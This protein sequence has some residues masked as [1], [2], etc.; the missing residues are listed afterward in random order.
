MPW[1]G[2]HLP[3][4][5]ARYWLAMLF[6][7][8]IGTKLGDYVYSYPW[9]YDQELPAI[10]AVFVVVLLAENF[11]KRATQFYYWAVIVMA[12]A[13]ATNLAD[14][15]PNA[16]GFGVY[17][18]DHVLGALLAVTLLFGGFLSRGVALREGLPPVDLR[19][20][21]AMTT[22]SMLACAA[23]D[24]V[25]GQM[26]V[27]LALPSVL[28]G[29]AF[30]LVVCRWLRKTEAHYWLLIA[31]ALAAGAVGADY[32]TNAWSLSSGY[33]MAGLIIALGVLVRF[34][35]RDTS[36]GGVVRGL[37]WSACTIWAFSVKYRRPLSGLAIVAFGAW[38]GY[39]GYTTVLPLQSA[40]H[41][42]Y[43]TGVGQIRTDFHNK[44]QN[45]SQYVNPEVPSLQKSLLYYKAQAKA[46]LLDRLLY[47]RPDPALAAQAYLK[48]G[49]ILLYNA[50]HDDKLLN[51][52]KGY[53]ETAV[54]LN[55]GIPYARTLLE[56]TGSLASVNDL[57]IMA[58]APERDLEMLY[59][60]NPQQR[61]PKPQKGDG[62]SK[63][64][65]DKKGDQQG[66]PDQPNDQPGDQSDQKND[67]QA[68]ASMNKSLQ[69]NPNDVKN[70]VGNDGI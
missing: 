19:Y 17:N 48:I 4:V 13:T 51:E 61:T 58:L 23:G 47:G 24:F 68:P 29:M 30:M 63:S 26:G 8:L 46:G 3:E 37:W 55:P 66:E 49:V 12:Q 7:S 57:A 11:S 62:K 65:G 10:A 41:V 67:Q 25:V 33:T 15:A 18:L 32:L 9:G 2:E 43:N 5:D 20:W 45:W 28:G 70:G 39:F 44:L 52:A 1:L 6:A 38:L 34:W 42:W 54:A 31:V 64:E 35:R 22:V 60:S 36:W 59:A 53:L 50:G 16:T 69:Q 14:Y 40:Q 27:N 21:L 56:N